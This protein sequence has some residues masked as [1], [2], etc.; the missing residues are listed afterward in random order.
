[1]VLI[2]RRPLRSRCKFTI[3]AEGSVG[4]LS[5]SNVEKVCPLNRTSPLKVPNHRKPSAV[6]TIEVAVFCGIPWSLSQTSML[7]FVSAN[8]PASTGR[9][10]SSQRNS[11]STKPTNERQAGE[12]LLV[13]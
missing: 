4:V 12:P 5:G 1:M 8:D 2:H 7:Y 13:I 3:R 6:W 10:K 11:I 9:D